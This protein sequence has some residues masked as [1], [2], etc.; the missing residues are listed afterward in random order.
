MDYDM[1]GGAKRSNAW[2]QYLQTSAVRAQIKSA[3]AS[4]K[5]IGQAI[6]EV[7]ASAPS[8]VGTKR[9]RSACNMNSASGSCL[10][11]DCR[12][13]TPTKTNKRTKRVARAFC[14]KPNSTGSGRRGSVFPNSL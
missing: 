3:I 7:R 8:T 14:R 9:V 1:Y 5:S 11:P 10:P 6:K 4:G 13:V 12:W 2:T